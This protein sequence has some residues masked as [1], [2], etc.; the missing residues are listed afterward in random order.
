MRLPEMR[1]LIRR[2]RIISSLTS[3]KVRS[4]EKFWSFVLKFA[5]GLNQI[6]LISIYFR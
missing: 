3:T 2:S 1:K 6:S 5:F 4:E